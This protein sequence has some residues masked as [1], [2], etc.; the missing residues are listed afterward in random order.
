M[1][2][3]LYSGEVICPSLIST[4]PAQLSSGVAIP[5]GVQEMRKC[6]TDRHG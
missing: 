2:P 4:T 5:G 6:G 1:S 3:C